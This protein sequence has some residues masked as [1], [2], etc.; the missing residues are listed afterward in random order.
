MNK[1]EYLN[2]IT[3][4]AFFDELQ[5][6]SACKTPGKKIK[7]K[8]MGRGRSYGKGDGPIGIPYKKKKK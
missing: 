5:K 7:S 6:L 2:E 3:K 1:S 4:K 8:E